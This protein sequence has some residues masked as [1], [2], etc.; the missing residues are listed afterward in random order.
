MHN[1]TCGGC[2][3]QKKLYEQ[4]CGKLHLWVFQDTTQIKVLKSMA[5]QYKKWVGIKYRTKA[6]L[7]LS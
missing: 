7:Q 4:G 5:F 6:M 3:I 2:F 1:T